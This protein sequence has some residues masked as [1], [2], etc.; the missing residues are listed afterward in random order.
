VANDHRRAAFVAL[1]IGHLRRFSLTP[2][3]PGVFALLRVILARDEGPKESTASLQTTTALGT[4]F[5]LQFGQVVRFADQL[6]EI[7]A[8]D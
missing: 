3:G 8:L 2:K 1:L 7:S 5:S 6:R 4:A